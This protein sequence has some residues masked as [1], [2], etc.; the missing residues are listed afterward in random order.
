MSR[1]QEERAHEQPLGEEEAPSPVHCRPLDR[2]DHVP[3]G[4]WVQLILRRAA[5]LRVRENTWERISAACASPPAHARS[6]R[7]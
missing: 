4:R 7:S 3:Q 2:R 6:V 1:T 5:G